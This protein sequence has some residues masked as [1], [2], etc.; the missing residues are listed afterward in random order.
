[1]Y[2]NSLVNTNQACYF[3]NKNLYIILLIMY[4]RWVLWIIII[5]NT[6]YSIIVIIAEHETRKTKCIYKFG[7]EYRTLSRFK[8]KTRTKYL[9]TQGVERTGTGHL[10]RWHI[11]LLMDF[12]I[13]QKL[14]GLFLFLNTSHSLTSM[15]V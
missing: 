4:S 13:P 11:I 7:C 15:I 6:Q 2:W 1:M 8:P 14:Q 9:Q 3:K 5:N 12:R 10:V